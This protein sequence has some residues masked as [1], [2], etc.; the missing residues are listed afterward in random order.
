MRKLTYFTLLL[1]F[2]VFFQSC[3]TS[4][5]PVEENAEF[6]ASLSDFKDYQNW[7][8]TDTKY[9][10]DPLLQ[11]AHGAE[12]GV[13]RRIY[14]KDNAQPSNGKYPTGTIVLKELRDFDGN[15]VGGIT[16]MAK[17]G[18]S[19]NSDGNGWEWFMTDTNLETILTQGDNA[20]ALDGMCATCHAG[21]N[22]NDNGADWVFKHPDEKEFVADLDDFKNYSDWSLVATEFGP[23]PLLS[24]AHGVDDSLYRR[25]YVKDNAKA[26]DGSYLTGTIV[27]KELRDKDGNIQGGITIMVK[28]GGSFNVNGNGWEWFMTDTNLENIVTRGDN[29]TAMNGMCASC[30]AGA[31]TNSNGTDW[32]FKHDG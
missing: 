14:V 3:S 4:N 6:K 23:D 18:G 5:D 20:T 9:G 28:R 11:T 24:T 10:P 1:L 29:L 15:L 27:L 31:N 17:R 12:D 32:V 22:T 19:F 16:I 26:I 21:A 7:T 30:H 13:V 25:I 8:K 2:A